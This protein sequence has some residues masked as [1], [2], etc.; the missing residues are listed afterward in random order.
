MQDTKPHE[1]QT[2]S[3]KESQNTWVINQ[4]V[5][6]VGACSTIGGWDNFLLKTEYQHQ[7]YTETRLN[8]LCLLHDE[9]AFLSE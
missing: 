1:M 8:Y 9:H 4:F 5:V 7:H 6:Y 3:V 2:L